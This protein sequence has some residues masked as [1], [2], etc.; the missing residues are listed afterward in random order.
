MF[1]FG[2]VVEMYSAVEWE[3]LGGDHVTRDFTSTSYLM[4]CRCIFAKLT[5]HWV[6][7]VTKLSLV[8][9]EHRSTLPTSIPKNVLHVIFKYLRTVVKA[10]IPV[11][12]LPP[13]SRSISKMLMLIQFPGVFPGCTAADRPFVHRSQTHQTQFGC[14]WWL[15]PQPIRQNKRAGTFADTGAWQYDCF[16]QRKGKQQQ[17][18]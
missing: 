1:S 11:S 18:L 12:Q 2:K 14:V 13:D 7:D 10:E 9:P 8:S 16:H 15:H 5:T 6:T 17:C 3:F 4:I